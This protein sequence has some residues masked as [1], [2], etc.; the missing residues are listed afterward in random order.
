MSASRS[1]INNRQIAAT[2]G[3]VLGASALVGGFGVS[4]ASAAMPTGPAVAHVQ[5][6]NFAKGVDAY[7][8]NETDSDLQL[9][10]RE[11]GWSWSKQTLGAR[12][13]AEFKGYDKG[14]A[15]VDIFGSAKHSD[16][17]KVYFELD[18]DTSYGNVARIGTEVQMKD[19]TWAEK[20]IGVG[21]HWTVNVDGRNYSVDRSRDG[22]KY[23]N[24]TIAF[25]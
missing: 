25:G 8:Y 2:L 3:A 5:A 24:M 11:S 22:A 12:S 9:E 18:E 4:A 15:G 23:T 1:K 6:P 16:G 17:T 14:N 13:E 21:E 7:A 19:H 20:H 10:V